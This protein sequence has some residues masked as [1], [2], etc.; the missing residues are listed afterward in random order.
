MLTN[1]G[2]NASAHAEPSPAYSRRVSR[3]RIAELGA[4]LGDET[5]VQLLTLLLDGRASTVGELA[6]ASHVALS[7]ASGHLARLH[8]AGLVGVQPQGRHRYYRLAGPEVAG[9]LEAMQA[10]PAPGAAGGPPGRDAGQPRAAGSDLLRAASTVPSELRFARTCYD[11]LAGTLAVTL[12][13]LLIT[14][15]DGVPA[16]VPAAPAAL[17]LLG[18]SETRPAGSRR[19]RLRDCLDWS[20]RRPHLAGALGAALLTSL[21]DR[22][23]LVRRRTPRAVRLTRAGAGALA[24]AFGPHPCWAP[25]AGQH[26]FRS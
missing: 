3:S 16:L 2:M 22:G 9:L 1:V 14:G 10:L 18:V 23:W 6:R 19:P 20:E 8:E 4:L 7:T 17:A 25:A 13:D 15:D 11:H 26:G 21:L 24:T 12:H 5:R